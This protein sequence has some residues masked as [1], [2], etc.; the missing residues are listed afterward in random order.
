MI[1]AVYNAGEILTKT[2][3]ERGRTTRMFEIY[4][5]NPAATDWFSIGAIVVASIITGGAALIGVRLGLRGI[6]EEISNAKHMQEIEFDRRDAE[7]QSAEERRA[8]RALGSMAAE[9]FTMIN[10]LRN[11]QFKNYVEFFLNVVENNSIPRA[12]IPI[13]MQFRN[14]LFKQHIGFVSIYYDT[15]ATN[16]IGLYAII[17]SLI[18]RI[19]TIE[20]HIDITRMAIDKVSNFEE[21]IGKLR[22][23]ILVLERDYDRI[24]ERC[25]DTFENIREETEVQSWNHWIDWLDGAIAQHR[26]T[27]E[28]RNRESAADAELEDD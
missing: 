18:E 22:S 13:K 24:F 20:E 15:S 14:D 11:S 27:A 8:R 6:A 12:R 21:N 19:E 17:E 28:A 16:V 4:I 9:V 7:M 25:R 10:S 23:S 26:A 3:S 5:G 2:R 1:G